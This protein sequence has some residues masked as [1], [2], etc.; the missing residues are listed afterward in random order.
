MIQMVAANGLG[1]KQTLQLL[2]CV[3]TSVCIGTSAG[4]ITFAKNA[5]PACRLPC[6]FEAPTKSQLS[7]INFSMLAAPKVGPHQLGEGDILA[8]TI[9]GV[10]PPDPKSLPPV[11]Q[12]QATLNREYYPPRGTI[13]APSYGVPI[14]VQQNGMVQLP[15]V[16]AISLD[17]LSLAEAAEKIRAEYVKEEIVREG[18]DQVNIV[19][20]RSRVNRIVV[21]REDASLQAAN[22]SNAGEVLQHK[23]GSAAV[24]DLPIYESDVLHALSTTGGLPGVDAYNEV[25]VLR[26]SLLNAG[27]AAM[28]QDLIASGQSPTEA[29][30]QVASHVDAIRIPLKLC[31]G[32]PIPFAP[33]DVALN[34]GDVI[35]IEP[36]KDEY[37]YTGGLLPGRQIPL[38]RDEDIDVLEAIAIAQGSVG[39]YGGTSGLNGVTLGSGAGYVLPPTRVLVIRKLPNGQQ[40]QIKVDLSD[41][42]ENPKERLRIMA[43]DYLMMYYKPGQAFSNAALGFF[44]I[45]YVIPN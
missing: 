8:I 38:P 13:D 19:L 40:L 5:I 28:M 31:C 14:H 3:L 39:G 29:I 6:Q 4:C 20:L 26:N 42:K 7:P 45:N 12:G 15:L 23:R 11:I 41:A 16:D 43:G 10:I 30:G 9:Q 34:D 1:K 2:A 37:F 32:E 21:L 22:F 25:W 36:R 18:N 44:N 17:G 35:Y 24:I 27:D 33:E